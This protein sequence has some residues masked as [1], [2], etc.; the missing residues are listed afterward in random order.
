[1]Q[2]TPRTSAPSPQGPLPLA[3]VRRSAGRRADQVRERPRAVE[4]VD[5]EAH[6]DG[7]GVRDGFARGE[8]FGGGGESAFG[9]RRRAAEAALGGCEGARRG[10]SGE[11]APRG[12]VDAQTRRTPPERGGNDAKE[13][14]VVSPR[15]N[16]GA[17][18]RKEDEPAHRAC[19]ARQLHR[20]P[21]AP[22]R[23]P[24]EVRD[25]PHAPK[26]EVRVGEGDPGRGRGGGEVEEDGE[27]GEGGGEEEVC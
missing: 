26:I 4:G 3:K 20:N 22:V 10:R 11:E 15:F 12:A 17:E 16:R 18:E 9:S 24:H 25:V 14:R 1:M 8:R 23:G 19:P 6:G 27:G 2:M 21:A 7:D 5:R 13:Q